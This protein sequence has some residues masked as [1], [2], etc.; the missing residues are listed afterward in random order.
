MVPY[1]AS[2]SVHVLPAIRPHRLDVLCIP[3][4]SGP[5]DALNNSLIFRRQMARLALQFGRFD[6]NFIYQKTS[7][8]TGAIRL[9]QEFWPA[10]ARDVYKRLLEGKK[11]VRVLDP[12]HGWG[13][14]LIGFMAA[15]IHGTYYG[16]DPSTRTSEGCKNLYEFLKASGVPGNADFTTAPFEAAGPYEQFDLVFTSP[17]YYDTER[18]ADEDTQA[19]KCPTYESFCEKFYRPMIEKSVNA[20]KSGGVFA[21]NIGNKQYKL[22]DEARSIMSEMP[23]TVT[24]EKLSAFSRAGITGNDSD[25][26]EDLILASKD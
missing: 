22:G 5:A 16:V 9:A 13:G 6:L 19:W 23:V 4:L 12:C 1:A 10:T 26:G 25:E 7:L 20:L 3:S 14:R 2:R 11:N 18:Y 21:L 8:G 24:V 15:Q 17:P